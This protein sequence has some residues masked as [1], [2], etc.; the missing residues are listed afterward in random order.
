MSSVKQRSKKKEKAAKKGG[1]S[2]FSALEVE[3]DP[4]AEAEADMA[5]TADSPSASPAQNG[6]T[7]GGFAA[8]NGDAEDEDEESEGES[9]VASKQA[10][11]GF[12]ALSLDE[13]EPEEEIEQATTGF[14]ALAVEGEEDVEEDVGE[15]VLLPS[16]K[17]NDKVTL[18]YVL[19][20]ISHQQRN[21]P[22][23]NHT[24]MCDQ[25]PTMHSLHTNVASANHVCLLSVFLVCWP[26]QAFS[27]TD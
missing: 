5:D 17:K 11:A 2:A 13:V 6:K 23:L 26:Q 9:P 10:A 24:T 3:D 7:N 27:D 12:A 1:F 18:H 16:K 15:P 25:G 8:L 22:E 19:L 4:E 21:A 14:A 20:V